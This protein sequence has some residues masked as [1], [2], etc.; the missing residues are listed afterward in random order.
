MIIGAC[1]NRGLSLG[2]LLAKRL[3]PLFADCTAVSD[4]T[5]IYIKPA[6]INTGVVSLEAFVDL[7]A[8]CKFLIILS[9]AGGPTMRGSSKLHDAFVEHC[10]D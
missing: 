5:A 6:L 8:L 10:G 3:G 2:D 1:M 4:K 9:L 7:F